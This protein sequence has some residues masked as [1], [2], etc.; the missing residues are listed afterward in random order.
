MP[1]ALDYRGLFE[2]FHK[3]TRA[4]RHARFKEKRAADIVVLNKRHT[5]INCRTADKVF[6]PGQRFR[7][8]FVDGCPG[9]GCAGDFF[10][11]G[12]VMR[13]ALQ[14]AGCEALHSWVQKSAPS[15]YPVKRGKYRFAVGVCQGKHC[16]RG[17]C[18]RR[19]DGVLSPVWRGTVMS[20]RDPPGL[21]CSYKRAAEALHCALQYTVGIVCCLSGPDM[22]GMPL[23]AV[24]IIGGAHIL[25]SAMDRRTGNRA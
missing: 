14:A 10:Y 23:P 1:D 17:S 25:F 4:A 22:T 6:N 16:L 8:H 15:L 7:R 19:V 11:H 18:G 2:P 21:L 9:N 3:Q 24:F 20:P 13:T 5:R 12:F